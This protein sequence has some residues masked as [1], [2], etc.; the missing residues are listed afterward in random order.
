MKKVVLVAFALVLALSLVACGRTK[1]TTPPELT[2]EWKQTNSAS[3][4]AWQAATIQG[5]TIEV[6]WVSD[7]GDTESLY[8]AGTF[9]APTTPD[10]PYTWDSVNDKSKTDTALLASP[11]DTKTFTYQN[12]VLS[13]K[14]SALGTTTTVKLEKQS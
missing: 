9:I 3:A 2:G 10:E 4:D 8:W 6:Y 11:D 7:N 13:Y 12:G 14:V 5:D 1:S